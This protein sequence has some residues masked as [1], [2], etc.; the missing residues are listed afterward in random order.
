MGH[1]L[2]R[3]KK[4]WQYTCVTW[5]SLQEGL[6]SWGDWL[7]TGLIGIWTVSSWW[8]AKFHATWSYCISQLKNI[9]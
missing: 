8:G 2:Q 7:G 3:W 1:I 5:E 9:S 4:A 6:E